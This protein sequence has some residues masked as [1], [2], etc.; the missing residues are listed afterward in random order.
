M[1]KG[2]DERFNSN[3]RITSPI[4]P[5]W[6]DG[7]PFVRSEIWEAAGFPGERTLEWTVQ[8]NREK[9]IKRQENYQERKARRAKKFKS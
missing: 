5:V 8:K 7:D 4:D 9:R 3:R 1:A 6:V 2:K